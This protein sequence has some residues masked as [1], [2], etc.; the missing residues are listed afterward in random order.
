MRKEPE[1]SDAEIERETGCPELHDRM[2]TYQVKALFNE[3]PR[4]D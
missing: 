1:C 2:D 3:L 4:R